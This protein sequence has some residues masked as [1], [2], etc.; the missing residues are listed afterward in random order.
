MID[1]ERERMPQRHIFDESECTTFIG[2]VKGCTEAD[3]RV[4]KEKVE[5]GRAQ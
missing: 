5:D 2:L 3:L 4:R 1:R